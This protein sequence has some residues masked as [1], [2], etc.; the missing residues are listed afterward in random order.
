VVT[1]AEHFLSCMA[2]ALGTSSP[3]LDEDAE[4]LLRAHP[5]N[6]NV[7][8]LQHVMERASILAGDADTIGAE[9]LYFS[10]E[11]GKLAHASTCPA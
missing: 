8:E 9:H 3:R 11:F 7:R 10:R 4:R 6:G 1:L 5:W 2:A